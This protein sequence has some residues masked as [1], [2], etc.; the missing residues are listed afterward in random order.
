MVM[1]RYRLLSFLTAAVMV[2]ALALPA[3]GLAEGVYTPGTYSATKPGMRGDVVVTMTFDENSILS[4]EA[5][6]ASET[7]NIGTLALEQLPGIILE[8]QSAQVDAIST[9]TVTSDAL[10]AAASICIQQAKGEY[11]EPEKME[12][13]TEADVLVLGA[14]ASGLAAATK[15]G[16]AGA[17]VIVLEANS[18]VGGAAVIS[19]GNITYIDPEFNTNFGRNDDAL[20]K[21]ADY[22]DEDFPGGWG[23]ELRT[24]REEIAEYMAS[25]RTDAFDSVARIMVDHYKFCFGYDLDGNPTELDY[26]LTKKAVEANQEI[27]EELLA[28]GLTKKALTA[29]TPHYITPNN[30]GSEQIAI[31]LKL[32]E[33]AGATI[34]LNTRATEL[35]TDET[36]R[37]IGAKATDANGDEVTFYGTKGV[38][39]ATGGFA[40]NAEMCAE[41]Q[42]VGTSMTAQSKTDNPSTIQGD[43]ILMTVALGA[44]LRNMQFVGLGTTDY[45]G[46][47]SKPEAS[48]ALNASQLVVNLDGQR[49]WKNTSDTSASNTKAMTYIAANQP[50]GVALF[51][52]DEKMVNALLEM[53]EDYV[54]DLKARGLLFT[55]DTLEGLA[56]QVNCN[57]EQLSE[58]IATFNGYVDQGEDPDFG[59]EQFNGKVE[60]GPYAAFRI[61]I[62]YHLTFGGI[63]TNTEAEVLD[64]QGQ[65]IPGLYAAGDVTSGIEGSTHLTGDCMLACIY[66]GEVAGLNAAAN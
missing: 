46:G 62:S 26:E 22:K 48:S 30:T 19:G 51:I 6:G 8:A 17:S 13:P 32:A 15:A 61:Q 64:A 4:V 41:Y 54:S 65:P 21:Y 29:E 23:D 34:I 3:A 39:V 59:R 16:Q 31:Q 12:Y 44:Q 2:L 63:I 35:V 37:V 60:N 45:V 33:E 49:F 20:A 28:A 52:G 56:A 36:G 40:A 27:G 14:G 43:G 38:I 57:A 5:V 47:P 9:A 1:K 66:Y 25:D 10:I 50:E 42:N 7:P 58:T 55:D 53:G 24:L 18:H 11:V